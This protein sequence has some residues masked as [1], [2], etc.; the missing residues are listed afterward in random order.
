MLRLD[1]TKEDSSKFQ[2]FQGLGSGLRVQ[3]PSWPNTTA[4]STLA[5]PESDLLG[6]TRLTYCLYFFISVS[7]TI[8]LDQYNV[9][10]CFV[11]YFVCCFSFHVSIY[12]NRIIHFSLPVRWQSDGRCKIIIIPGS[13]IRSKLKTISSETLK[14]PATGQLKS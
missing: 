1:K 6:V 12:L 10:I 5:W 14:K 11:I 8:V 2:T 9:Q 3:A 7:Q 4:L 13:R